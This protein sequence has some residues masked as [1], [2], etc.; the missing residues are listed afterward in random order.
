MTFHP[1]EAV[2]LKCTMKDFDGIAFT[3]DTQEV[4]VYDPQGT[5]K[6]TYADPV[7]E[8]A[9]IYHVD[10]STADS[11]MPGMWKCIWKTTKS[12]LVSKEVF[13]FNIEA[14]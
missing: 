10:H 6:G 9:G 2:R 12:A 14:I 4:K 5:L 8:A 11:D 1:G 13:Y 3:P 7:L